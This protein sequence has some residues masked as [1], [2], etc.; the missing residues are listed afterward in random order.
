M[1]SSYAGELNPTVTFRPLD[2]FSLCDSHVDEGGSFIIWEPRRMTIY[3]PIVWSH[4]ALNIFEKKIFKRH[5][6]NPN[7]NLIIVAVGCIIWLSLTTV[8][9]GRDEAH[10]ILTNRKGTF[11]TPTSAA[12]LQI[13]N[14]FRNKIPYH[15]FTIHRTPATSPFHLFNYPIW[16]SQFCIM[17]VPAF[18][19]IA[20]ASN[21]VS[22]L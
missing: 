20:K 15:H 10:D 12:F 21:D 4:C 11:R 13:S 2:P 18:S 6:T 16:S 7:P 14:F 1:I 5:V 17:S 22:A 8:P 19:D 9:Q 3:A